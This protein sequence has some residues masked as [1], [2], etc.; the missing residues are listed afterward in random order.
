MGMEIE[1]NIKLILGS[2]AIIGTIVGALKY[3]YKRG[4]K[5]QS[6]ENR[7]DNIIDIIERLE[8]NINVW[9]DD[10]KKEIEEETKKAHTQH[11]KLFEK[12]Q[13]LSDEI[14]YIKGR[15]DQSIH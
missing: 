10:V 8:T 2:I 14:S 12:L 11:T 1:Y 13:E 15:F 5:E 7:I 3:L 6:E 4:K 9:R